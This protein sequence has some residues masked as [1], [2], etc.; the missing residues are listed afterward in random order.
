MELRRNDLPSD[1]TSS[2]AHDVARQRKRLASKTEC[3]PF[4]IS[5]STE[6]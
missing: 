6:G 4:V 5:K 2:H 1:I 3:E